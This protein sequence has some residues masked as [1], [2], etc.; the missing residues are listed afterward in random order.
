MDIVDSIRFEVITGP[1]SWVVS[2]I[3]I[4]VCIK[5]SSKNA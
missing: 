3:H 2:L 1:Q 4:Y 5:I